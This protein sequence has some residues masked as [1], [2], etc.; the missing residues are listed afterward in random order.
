MEQDNDWKCGD[1]DLIWSCCLYAEH[2]S[3]AGVKKQVLAERWHGNH[4]RLLWACQLEITR[5]N[6]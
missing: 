1:G 2:D 6:V 5:L 3:L 4:G